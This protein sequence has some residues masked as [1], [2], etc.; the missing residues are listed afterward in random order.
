MKTC[1]WVVQ[2]ATSETPAEYCGRKTKYILQLDQ[3][4]GTK[5]RVYDSLCPY[6]RSVD[7]AAKAQNPEGDDE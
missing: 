4:S 3:D 6:H 1:C 7:E 5:V 2:P